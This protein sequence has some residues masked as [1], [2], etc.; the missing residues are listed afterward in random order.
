MSRGFCMSKIWLAS[1]YPQENAGEW[2]KSVRVCAEGPRVRY[3]YPSA[4][5]ADAGGKQGRSARPGRAWPLG[6]VHRSV[7]IGAGLF[8]A[9]TASSITPRGLRVYGAPMRL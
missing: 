3:T 6:L 7:R 5:S 9:G 4:T 1:R 2:A 8:A